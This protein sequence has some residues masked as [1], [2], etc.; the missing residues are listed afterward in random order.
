MCIAMCK[1]IILS[2]RFL[3]VLLLLA[4]AFIL[5]VII[6]HVKHFVTMLKFIIV[7]WLVKSYEAPAQGRFHME[8]RS[9]LICRSPMRFQSQLLYRLMQSYQT[10][11]P[12][13]VYFGD[14]RHEQ[15]SVSWE[16]ASIKQIP[17]E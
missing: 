12:N 9:V 10:G 1:C 4:S 14:S 8:I 11:V 5:C 7:A 16:Y 2:L 3:I 17:S 6:Y 15:F 13:N